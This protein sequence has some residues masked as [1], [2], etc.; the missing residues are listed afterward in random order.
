MVS[1]EG[2]DDALTTVPI[3]GASPTV[4]IEKILL[5]LF[6]KTISAIVKKEI[7]LHEITREYG[8]V[9]AYDEHMNR[10]YDEME[11]HQRNLEHE[12]QS[13]QYSSWEPDPTLETCVQ[14][15]NATYDCW[16]FGNTGPICER[17]QEKGL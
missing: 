6:P 12:S 2:G 1:H 9:E 8:S 7:E 3:G 14:C 15:G 4:M 10:V 5:W 11:E 17:C 13:T 16:D